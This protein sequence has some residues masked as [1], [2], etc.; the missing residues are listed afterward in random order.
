[1]SQEIHQPRFHEL[2]KPTGSWD[3]VL[4]LEVRDYELDSQGIVNNA[5][6][7]NYYEHCRHRYLD[8]RGIHFTYLQ[9]Q[10]IDP[11]VSEV[12]VKYLYSLKSR[13]QFLVCLLWQTQGRFKQVFQQEIRLSDNTLVS[14]AEFTV[15]TLIHGK[16]GYS[17][18]LID[19]LS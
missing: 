13:D 10:G 11:V 12:R 6:Y 2:M 8:H 5:T 15:A 18:D 7:L 14:Q 16:I 17:Q 9:E 1:M 4:E 19:K 3:F